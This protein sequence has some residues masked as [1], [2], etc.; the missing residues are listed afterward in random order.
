V[1]KYERGE[2]R[3]DVVELVE[4]CEAVGLDPAVFV[5]ELSAIRPTRM[6]RAL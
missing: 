5:A 2:R 6:R 4:V 3:L 1:S